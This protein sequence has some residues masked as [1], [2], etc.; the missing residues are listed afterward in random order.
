MHT[1]E[2][3]THRYMNNSRN[4]PNCRAKRTQ[5][6]SKPFR[7]TPHSDYMSNAIDRHDNDCIEIISA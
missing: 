1:H 4:L 7:V 2:R 3:R 5:A 6:R